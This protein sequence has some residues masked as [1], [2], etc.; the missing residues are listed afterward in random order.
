M[1]AARSFLRSIPLSI[2]RL[3]NLECLYLPYIRLRHLP[4]EI[5]NLIHLK[6]LILNGNPI[7]TLPN[8]IA[9]LRKLEVLDLGSTTIRKFP[10]PILDLVSLRELKIYGLPFHV[11]S[12][13]DRLQ[14][15]LQKLTLGDV[16]PMPRHLEI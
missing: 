10:D 12:I 4:A 9:S 13:I 6:K 11:P 2:G 7:Q 8:T 3:K 15:N 16:I 14:Q 5:G 1:V